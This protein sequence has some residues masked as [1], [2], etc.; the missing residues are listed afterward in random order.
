[1]GALHSSSEDIEVP[2]QRSDLTHC[3]LLA[4]A[5]LAGTTLL[6]PSVKGLTA[7]LNQSTQ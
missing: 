2:L 6:S 7:V 5:E 3:G 1:M 4:S